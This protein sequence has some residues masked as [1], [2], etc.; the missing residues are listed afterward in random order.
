MMKVNMHLYVNVKDFQ[1]I[2]NRKTNKT[3]SLLLLFFL[4]GFCEF[5]GQLVIMAYCDYLLSCHNSANIRVDLAGFIDNVV[6]KL[7][8]L[9]VLFFF[10]N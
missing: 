2:E 10:F 8:V 7:V 4:F 5:C 1:F 3:G 6:V 9:P